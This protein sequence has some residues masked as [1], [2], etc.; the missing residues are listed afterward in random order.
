MRKIGQRTPSLTILARTPSNSHSVPE[1]F[2]L[3]H[4]LSQYRIAASVAVNKSKS[5][6]I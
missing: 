1:D 4:F 5:C 6:S 3:R 2:N